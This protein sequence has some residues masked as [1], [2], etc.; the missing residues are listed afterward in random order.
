[1]NFAYIQNSACNDAAVLCHTS[2]HEWVMKTM[3]P[4]IQQKVNCAVNTSHSYNESEC[5]SRQLSIDVIT[6]GK[7]IKVI[8]YCCEGII[9]S[10]VVGIIVHVHH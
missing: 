5:D 10:A 1:M 6:I 3:M 2:N 8:V 9:I 4:K 7:T